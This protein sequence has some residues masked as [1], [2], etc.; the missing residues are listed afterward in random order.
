MIRCVRS[1][2][3]GHRLLLLGF[4]SQGVRA[5]F[6]QDLSCK[7]LTCTHEG[8]V[9]CTRSFL[10]CPN[11][12]IPGSGMEACAMCASCEAPTECTPVTPPAAESHGVRSRYMQVGT[13]PL[14]HDQCGSAPTGAPWVTRNALSV[15]LWGQLPWH[16][17]NLRGRRH[18]GDVRAGSAPERQGRHRGRCAALEYGR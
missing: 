16:M 5:F 18:A 4:P 15:H 9:T 7:P 12:R 11:T 13:V 6:F 14:A 8:C 1:V 3:C 10:E 2:R 17:R